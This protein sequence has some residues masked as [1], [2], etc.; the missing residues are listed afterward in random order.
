[1]LQAPPQWR[2]IDLLSDLHLSAA[3]P[4]TV[5]AFVEHLACTDAQAVF[6]L[7][8]LFEV[9]VGN[10]QQHEAVEAQVL[11]AMAQAASRCWLGFMPGNRDF[12][13]SPEVLAQAETHTLPDPL[14]L[15]CFGHELLL[16]HGDALCL[17]DTEYQ[18]FRQQVRTPTWQSD[19][20]ARPYGERCALAA[21]IRAESQSRKSTRSQFSDWADVDAPAAQ[22]W[23]DQADAAILIH[24]HTHRPGEHALPGGGVRHVLSD[25]DLDGA[26]PRAQVMRLDATGLHR[27]APSAR[28]A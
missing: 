21:R 7:G 19:F 6:I 23:L 9:W 20:L 26:S 5:Q 14:K 16:T 28:R 10:E 12:L 22:R 25:W 11:R 17:D 27:E 3:L 13:L 24:G 8:D 18:A 4:R 15:Q 1:M 2:C